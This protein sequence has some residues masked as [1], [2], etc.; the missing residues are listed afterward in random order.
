MFSQPEEQQGIATADDLECPAKLIERAM[1]LSRAC[2]SISIL[3]TYTIG[4]EP[5][6][7]STQLPSLS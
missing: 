4:I 5:T 3:A 1:I 7:R 2:S 6:I